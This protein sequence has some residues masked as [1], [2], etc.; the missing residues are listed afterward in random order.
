[1][2]DANGPRKAAAPWIVTLLLHVG[3]PGFVLLYLLGFFDG[4]L[5]RNSQSPVTR[6]VA[7]QAQ[8]HADRIESHERESKA[9]EDRILEALEAIR[10]GRR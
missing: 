1:M 9:R 10:E 3:V 7:H 8:M 5:P 2:S 4:V 6:I